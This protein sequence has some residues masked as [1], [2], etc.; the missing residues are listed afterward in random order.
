[1]PSEKVKTLWHP[2][3]ISGAVNLIQGDSSTGKSYLSQAI[4]TAL[5][6][7][8]ALPNAEPMPPCY[9]VIQNGENSLKG[10]VKPRLV[11]LG[12]DFKY[13]KSID[14]SDNPLSLLSPDIEKMISQ[15]K[16]KLF[17]ADPIQAFANIYNQQLMRKILMHLRGVGERHDCAILLVGHLRKS[18]TQSQYRGFGSQD[19]YN[20]IPSVMN[21]GR[22]NDDVRVMVHSKSNFFEVGTPMSFS[23][24][25]GFQWLGEYDI[26]LDELLANP[27][28]SNRERQRDKA[29]AFLTELLADGEVDSNEV[30]TLAKEAGIAE[31]TLRRAKIDL[32]VASVQ[33]ADKW[34]WSLE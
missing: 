4:I 25:G 30:L 32:G 22:V 13:I 8:Q 27:A 16:A 18:R 31:K 17:V 33:L 21:L 14:D 1:M 7:G 12:A 20:A 24:K 15:Y 34:V 28:S 10:V 23:L 9:V 5:T 11:E 19:I 26:T 3:I 6:T 29:K 2:Y